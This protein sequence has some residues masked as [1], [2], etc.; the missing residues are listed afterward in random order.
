MTQGAAYRRAGGSPGEV[1]IE[2]WVPGAPQHAVPEISNTTLCG[3]V[4]DFYLN[5]MQPAAPGSSTPV[6]LSAFTLE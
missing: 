6:T 2:S 4:L 3:S 1:V 5:F